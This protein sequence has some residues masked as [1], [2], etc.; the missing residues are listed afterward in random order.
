MVWPVIALPD[1][2]AVTQNIVEKL[3]M[4]QGKYFGFFGWKGV[5]RKT[6]QNHYFPLK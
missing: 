6:N 1:W 2:P 5:G 3:L 4:R